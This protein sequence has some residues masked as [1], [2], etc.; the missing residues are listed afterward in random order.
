MN[1]KTLK[2]SK[3]IQNSVWNVIEVVLSPLILFLFI[4]LFLKELGSQDYGIWMFVNSVVIIM[5]ALNLGLNF[6]TYKHISSSLVKKNESLLEIK[7]ELVKNKIGF[8]NS[9]VYKR[10][11][12]KIDNSLGHEDEWQ[13]FEYNFNQVHEEFFNQLKSKCPQLTHKDL[14][15]CAYIKM[16][17]LTKEIAPLLN[18]STRGLETHRYRL[19]RKL[20]LENNKSLADY[21]KN[22]K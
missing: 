1:F 15:L 10:L 16:N 21:L 3:N 22:F 8:D 11:L 14:K 12:R 13:L 2:S 18:V 6:S 17:L 20:N 9:S 7:V 5:Q 19:K 4:P